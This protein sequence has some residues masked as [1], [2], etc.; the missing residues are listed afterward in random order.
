MA[1]LLIMQ[2]LLQPPTEIPLLNSSSR[3]DTSQKATGPKSRYP[4]PL[5]QE[6]DLQS[7]KFERLLHQLHPLRLRALFVKSHLTYRTAP[8]KNPAWLRKRRANIEQSR[9]Y[10]IPEELVL[11]ILIYT[12]GVTKQVLRRTCNRFLRIIGGSDLQVALGLSRAARPVWYIPMFDLDPMV[13]VTRQQL[14]HFLESRPHLF[15]HTL[16]PHVTLGG[17]QLLIPFEP[18][19]YACFDDVDDATSDPC[20]R[21][22]APIWHPSHEGVSGEKCCRCLATGNPDRVGNFL[23]AQYEGANAGLLWDGSHTY[24]CTE[25]SATYAWNPHH[26]PPGRGFGVWIR[27]PGESPKT[28]ICAMSP[29]VLTCNA[30]RDCAGIDYFGY[31]F[32]SQMASD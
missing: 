9:L 27:S 29:G 5:L 15:G 19:Q 1:P 31:Y 17:G 3:P 23:P 8:D 18:N 12:D 10:Q 13:P 30:R 14:Q 25:C 6:A 7:S 20:Q 24:S 2:A 21:S 26:R 4:V 22:L 28:R 32:P 16:C 11:E